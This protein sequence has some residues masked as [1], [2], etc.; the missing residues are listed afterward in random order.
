M[1]KKISKTVSGVLACAVSATMTL[2][3]VTPS[4]ADSGGFITENHQ[5]GIAVTGIDQEAVSDGVV[6]IPAEI[7]GKTV[8]RLGSTEGAYGFLGRLPVEKLVIGENVSAITSNA[9]FGA[10]DL[11]EINTEQNA[12]FKVENGAFLA[13]NGKVLIKY[14][15]PTER[16]DYSVPDS[17]TTVYNMDHAEWDTLDLNDVSKMYQLTL[18]G[19]DIGTLNIG[20]DLTANNGHDILYGATVGTFTTEDDSGYRTNGDALWRD[21][22]LIKLS[23]GAGAGNLDTTFFEDFKSISPYAFNSLAQYQELESSIPEH[24]VKNTVFSFFSQNDAVFMIN[25]EISFCY[26]YEKEVPTTVGEAVDYS[27]AVDEEKY[28]QIKALMYVG[29]PFDG[30]GLFEEVF[31]VPYSEIAGNPDETAH[32]D[33][34]LNAVSAMVYHVID[35]VEP[36]EIRG[37]GYGVFD[38]AAVAA[39]MDG[40]KKAVEHYEDYN[41]EPEFSSQDAISFTKQDDGTYL[42]S[43][44]TINT[45]N[46]AG[47]LDDSY[48]YT[49][50]IKT[51]GITVSE[52]GAASFQTGDSVSFR[53]QEKPDS[54]EFTYNEPA[55]KYYNTD[56]RYQDILVSATREAELKLD[57]KVTVDDLV[58]S[59]VDLATGKELPGASLTLKKD[60]E[61]YDTWVSTDTPHLIQNPP[62]GMYELIEVTAPDGYEIAESILFEIR[63]G[64]VVGRNHIVMKDKPKTPK[65]GNAF[66][67]TDA[68][69]GDELPGAELTVTT[70]D[71][72]VIDRWTSTDTAHVIYDMEDGDYIM[73]ETTAPDGYEIAESIEFEVLNGEV[74]GGP[75]V[76]EDKPEKATP[77]EPSEPDEP[78]PP[79]TPSEPDEPDEPDTP[80]TPSEPDKPD[81]NDGPNGGHSGGGGGGG[82]RDHGLGVTPVEEVPTLEPDNPSKSD[83]TADYNGNPSQSQHLPKTDD[84]RA[85]GV[86]AVASMMTLFFL[87]QK[88]KRLYGEQ[89]DA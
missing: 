9:F 49:I 29:V 46:G 6:T 75:I 88:R 80:A 25:G 45:L 73:T 68:V 54:L 65:K 24:L 13:A 78:D 31:G 81:D 17:V 21:D 79:A 27:P 16:T 62:D 43:P 11:A 48:I 69:T 84:I 83:I 86:M 60:G 22:R 37:T 89:A 67:K 70:K 42:S 85:A 34:A 36:K 76:M 87:L 66:Y 23:V 3:G 39:Y 74:V 8:I 77:S 33:A 15:S 53:S 52:T 64:I 19:S 14:L 38:E 63:D 30:T 51:E 72:T 28:N 61:V 55:L 41:F 35:G 32:G 82:D 44:I 47:E 20:S 40:L 56:A 18:A 50:N 57:T 4:Y 1:R 2:S 71:G 10:N 5:D 59:K 26:D 12:R 58:I 7:D